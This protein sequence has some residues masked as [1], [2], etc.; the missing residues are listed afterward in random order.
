[1]SLHNNKNKSGKPKRNTK[2][3]N[4]LKE[5]LSTANISYTI[6]DKLMLTKANERSLP[7]H[8]SKWQQ[9]IYLCTGI[10]YSGNWTVEKIQRYS[11]CWS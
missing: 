8:Y 2:T 10:D 3:T 7:K 1:M 5:R 4:S 6:R 11:A 9:N